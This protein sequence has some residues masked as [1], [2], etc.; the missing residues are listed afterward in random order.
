MDCLINGPT[1]DLGVSLL[2]SLGGVSL[3]SETDNGMS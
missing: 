1:G 2:E 3:Y